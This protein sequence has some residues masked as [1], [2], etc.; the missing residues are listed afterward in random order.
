MGSLPFVKS[1]VLEAFQEDFNTIT[2]LLTLAY[3]HA[4]FAMFLFYYA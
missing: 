4:T 3:I 1:F 2:N